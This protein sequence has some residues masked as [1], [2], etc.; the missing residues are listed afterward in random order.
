M[1]IINQSPVKMVPPPAG[2]FLKLVR[3]HENESVC[4]CKKCLK[5]LVS[6]RFRPTTSSSLLF[7]PIGYYCR[8]KQSF[9]S[10]FV[11]LHLYST[12][13]KSACAKLMSKE[14][15]LIPNG[16]VVRRLCAPKPCKERCALP[17]EQ[18]YERNCIN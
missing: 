1:Y 12:L 2:K 9:I 16:G 4:R 14:E 18:F 7:T 17:A 3:L 13:N 10:V 8:H 5:L 11:G 6:Q 15:E